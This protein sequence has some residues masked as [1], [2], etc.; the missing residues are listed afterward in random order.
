MND[1]MIKEEYEQRWREWLERSSFNAN[2]E[3]YIYFPTDSYQIKDTLK[4]AGFRFHPYLLWHAPQ[5]IKGYEDKVIKIKREEVAEKTAYG[6]GVYFNDA[7]SRVQRRIMAALPRSN[8]RW[9]GEIKERLRNYIVTIEDIFKFA[10][11]YGLTTIVTFKDQ[12]ENLYK[13]FT[14]SDLSGYEIDEQVSLTGTVKDHI[15][16]KYKNNAQVTLLT[17][18][19]LEKLD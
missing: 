14:T 16:D 4:Q 17:R 2:E 3:T 12:Q 7:K 13:W 1:Q 8:S 11:H 18:C 5:I 6:L 10:G 19:K 9:Q 15:E